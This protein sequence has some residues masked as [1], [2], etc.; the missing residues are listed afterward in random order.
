MTRKFHFHHGESGSALAIRV[1]TRSRYNEISDILSD[2]TVKIRL[3]VSSLAGQ[4]NQALLNFLSNI[5][6][7]A[8]DRIDIVAG[9]TSK[10]KLVSIVGMDTASVHHKII[11]CLGQ[12]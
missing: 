9:E 8:V 10:D 11:A 2:G 4:E 5:L 1:I 12:S 7:I 3:T 6:G